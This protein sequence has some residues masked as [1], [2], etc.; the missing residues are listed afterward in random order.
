MQQVSLKA[1]KREKITKGANRQLRMVGSV[2]AVIYGGDGGSQA[3]SL[4]DRDL[5]NVLKSSA[6]LNVLINLEIGDGSSQEVQ[7]VIIKDI[8]KDPL[9]GSFVHIDFYRISMD[10][11]LKT[12]V[13]IEA[14]GIAQGVQIGGILEYVMRDV[15]VQCLPS[16]IPDKITVDVT[17]LKIRDSVH[18]RD[19]KVPEGVKLLDD[20]DKNV[21]SIV[22]PVA[23][24]VAAT[25]TEEI[26]EP[27]VI[28]RGKKEEEGAEETAAEGKD[29]KKAP[30]AKGAAPAAKGATPAAKGAAPA[31]GAEK[32]PGEKKSPEKKG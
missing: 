7:S 19:L 9:K 18:I 22:P 4:V 1:N 13:R 20:P 6:G 28:E 26:T 16:L 3:I 24:E 29:A 25:T 14:L 31:A 21:I 11:E 17:P 8:Q 27:E 12:R 10:K 30:E 15:L 23:E 5:H 32:K 2:P